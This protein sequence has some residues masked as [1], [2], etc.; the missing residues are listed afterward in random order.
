MNR[1]LVLVALAAGLLVW[2]AYARL[3]RQIRVAC[4]LAL[5]AA[6]LTLGASR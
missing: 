2:A 5:A 1:R 6:I 3:C 4:R